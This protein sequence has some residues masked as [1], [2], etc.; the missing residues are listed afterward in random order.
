MTELMTPEEREAWVAREARL[1]DFQAIQ[2][3][4]TTRRE[5]EARQARAD[6]G[7]PEPASAP[8]VLGPTDSNRYFDYE[9]L[10]KK[11]AAAA[12]ERAA[13]DRARN[14]AEFQAAQQ[15]A[16]DERAAFAAIAAEQER[17]Q[18][19]PTEIEQLRAEVEQMRAEI[20]NLRVAF[21]AER[22]AA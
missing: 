6:R 20:E 22:D 18:R 13:H 21:A 8:P 7:E 11:N 15:H 19:G 17:A 4:E 5:R 3:E 16:E 10:A 1:A 2:N 14:Q 9:V 12:A